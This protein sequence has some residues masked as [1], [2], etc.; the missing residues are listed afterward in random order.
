MSAWAECCW[1]SVFIPG[2]L[3]VQS[4]VPGLDALLVGVLVLAQER[5][6][7]QMACFLPFCILVQEGVGT[8]SF[9]ASML[10]YACALLLFSLGRDWFEGRSS[11][12]V[13]LVAC[14][15]AP[16]SVGLMS[17]LA[18]L[19]QLAVDPHI[20]LGRSIVQMFFL[21]PAWLLAMLT[22]RRIERV[23]A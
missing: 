21:P 12:L 11:V 20:L 22:R 14:A 4:L 15:L 23:Q 17:M 13:L 16:V 1:W 6:W 3:W 10:W 9:G 2:A 18:S 8:Q 19:Q 5:R 7:R